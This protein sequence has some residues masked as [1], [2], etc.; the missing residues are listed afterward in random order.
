MKQLNVPDLCRVLSTFLIAIL[1][2]STTSVPVEAEGLR[3]KFKLGRNKDKDN[4]ET[5]KV[6]VSSSP[7]VDAVPASPTTRRDVLFVTAPKHTTD[8]P[9]GSTIAFIEFNHIE[10]EFP[11][12]LRTRR[13]VRTT[14]EIIEESSIQKTVESDFYNSNICARQVASALAQHLADL[15]L[16]K[17]VSRDRIESILKEQNFANS[18]RVDSTTSARLGKLIGAD[19]LIYGEVQLCV[20]NRMSYG[21]IAAALQSAGPEGKGGGFLNNVVETVK[22]F[23]PEKMRSFVL[24]QIQLIEAQTGKR[25]FTT[26]LAG[27]FTDKT[28]ALQFDMKHRELIFRAADDLSNSFIDNFLSRPEASYIELYADSAWGFGAGIDLIQLGRC[29]RA[30]QYFSDI[31]AANRSAMKEDDVARLM[32]NHG[33]A[34]MCSNRPEEALDRLWASMRL[35]NEEATL[36]AIEFANDTIDRGRHIKAENDSIIL[37]VEEKMYPQSGGSTPSTID[38]SGQ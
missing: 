20:S 36:E 15:N 10:H 7:E 19:I 2:G 22:A 35:S 11:E 26:S 34:L 18:G 9:P 32:Y 38:T 14:D 1:L 8:I 12:Y 23:K 17:V 21:A 28:N 4:N 37:D 33:V 13:T 30:E 3:D 5:P 31:Y 27:E 29:P 16:Y 25:V 6:G 24:A